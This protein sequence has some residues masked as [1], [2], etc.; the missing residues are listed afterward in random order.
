MSTPLDLLLSFPP[1]SRIRRN[2]GL[3]HATLHLLAERFP[4][5]NMAGHSDTGGFWLLGDIPEDAVSQAVADALQRMQRGEH[6]LAVHPNCGTNF[7]TSGS[8]AG[9]A[10]AAA[11]WGAGKNWRDKA[12]RLSLAALLATIALI[13]SRPLGLWLQKYV[14]TSGHPGSLTVTEIR[15]TM[16]GKFP[17]YRVSTRG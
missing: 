3:E 15:R 7:V 6:Y 11:M 13:F 2:H 10:G 9:I 16:R 17:A 14:T 8:M 12:E 5:L 4:H 1:V